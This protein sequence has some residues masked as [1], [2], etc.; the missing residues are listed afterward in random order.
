MTRT[1]R[2]ALALLLVTTGIGCYRVNMSFGRNP[3]PHPASQLNRS[4]ILGLWALDTPIGL[5]SIC[6]T[7]VAAVEQWQ[8]VFA[9]LVLYLSAG[10]VDSRAIEIYC[11]DGAHA[12]VL[13]GEDG[14][15]EY[16]ELGD[17][18][19]FGGLPPGRLVE[20]STDDQPPS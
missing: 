9:G 14:L 13:L 5:D 20:A 10:I 12:R 8:G 19:T 11:A 3:A 7:G 4:F 2:L 18:A 16:V 6:P 17:T 1:V 15:I